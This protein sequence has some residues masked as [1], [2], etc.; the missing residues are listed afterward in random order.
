M[1]SRSLKKQ[2]I[3]DLQASWK[4][5]ALLGLLLCVG[6]YFWLPPIYRA[7]TGRG[8]AAALPATAVVSASASRPPVEAETSFKSSS[9][10]STG[11]PAWERLEKLGQTDPLIRS[12]EVAA[13]RS[14]PFLLN[15]DQFPPPVLFADEPIP[16]PVVAQVEPEE[17]QSNLD[18]APPG[19]NLILTSTLVGQQRRAAFINRRLYFEGAEMKIDGETYRLV[20]VA[21]RRAVIAYGAITF[22]LKIPKAYSLEAETTADGGTPSAN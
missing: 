3:R 11:G 9:G 7:L 14:E 1:A 2:L 22:E 6:C 21:P 10:E 12:A 5:T 17:T 13:I 8:K 20:S 15:H 18:N 16:M 19:A 4:K